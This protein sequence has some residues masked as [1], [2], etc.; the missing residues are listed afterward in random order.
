MEPGWRPLQIDYNRRARKRLAEEGRG[1]LWAWEIVMMFYEI[2]IAV[3]WY[4]EMRGRPAPKTHVERRAIVELHLPHLV[5]PY[6]D[7][8][9]VSLKARY[10]DGYAMTER[11]WRKAARHYKTLTEG[12][13]VR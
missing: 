8:Y 7:L 1:R 13:P 10:Y 6:E 12:I 2:V 5:D 9:G 3:D 11:A 4:A